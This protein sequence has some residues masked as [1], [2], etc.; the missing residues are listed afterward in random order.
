MHVLKFPQT[1]TPYETEK[2]F[3]MNMKQILAF[4]YQSLL[5]ILASL[6]VPFISPLPE[7]HRWDYRFAL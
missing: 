4:L 3:F 5:G 1:K 6:L 2:Y 7:L